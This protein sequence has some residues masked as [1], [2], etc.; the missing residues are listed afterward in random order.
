MSDSK[1]SVK[2]SFD[3]SL[4]T[5][6]T[7]QSGKNW[8]ITKRKKKTKKNN[9][10]LSPWAEKRDIEKILHFKPPTQKARSSQSFSILSEKSIEL[11]L[12]FVYS[13]VNASVQFLFVLNGKNQR[14]INCQSLGFCD[15]YWCFSSFGERLWWLWVYMCTWTYLFAWMWQIVSCLRRKNNNFSLRNSQ[16]ECDARTNLLSNKRK[17]KICSQ[18]NI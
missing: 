9:R 15:D 2:N 16:F 5:S 12:H 6:A 14:K 8:K 7:M 18:T 13:A 1:S 4:P 17:C 3:I 11:H 10:I